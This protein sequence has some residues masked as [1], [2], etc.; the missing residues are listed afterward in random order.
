MPNATPQATAQALPEATNRRAVLGAVLAVGAASALT[1]IAAASVVASHHPD[2]ELFALIEIAKTAD[3]LSDE[4]SAAAD[5]IWDRTEPSFPQELSWAEADA[6]HWH[7]VQPGQ[8]ISAR[9]ID[10]LR[11]WLKQSERWSQPDLAPLDIFPSQIFAARAREIVQL[12]DEFD[13]AARAAEEHPDVLGGRARQE[14]LAQRWRELAVRVATTPAK[15]MEGVVAKLAM[16]VPG[17][18]KYEPDGTFDGVL[19]SAMRDAL[20]L[21]N[22]QDEART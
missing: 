18:P 20:A 15:T 12:K 5:D 21:V 22:V 16:V 10:F 11:Y 1:A 7:G 8:Q 4:A 6:P 17:Y 13:A 2:A 3:A 19:S 9:D 14:T